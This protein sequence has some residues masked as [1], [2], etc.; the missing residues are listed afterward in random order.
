MRSEHRAPLVAAIVV[1]LA[2]VG[3]MAHAVRTDALGGFA[4][5]TPM[6]LIAGTV[7]EPKPRAETDAPRPSAAVALEAPAVPEATE[8]AGAPARRPTSDT[9]PVRPG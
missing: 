9:R 5:R 8:P 3:V 6:G 4:R 2:G 1:V 7:V